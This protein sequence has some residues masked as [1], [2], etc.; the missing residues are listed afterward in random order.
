MGVLLV[1]RMPPAFVA[2]RRQL[3]HLAEN[4]AVR[5]G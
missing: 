3:L 5:S 1:T 4:V 2:L